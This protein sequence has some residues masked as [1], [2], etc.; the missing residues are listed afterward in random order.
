MLHISNCLSSFV[1][2]VAVILYHSV[3]HKKCPPQKG[4]IRACLKSNVRLVYYK[5]IQFLHFLACSLLKLL[6]SPV[7]SFKFCLPRFLHLPWC[8]W[9][10]SRERSQ[11]FQSTK[12]YFSFS[13]K[14]CFCFSV[15]KEYMLSVGANAH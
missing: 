7:V 15:S 4:Y 6:I 13:T 14:A 10:L 9:K 12:F 11:K 8:L 2:S 1:H 3:Y 5:R